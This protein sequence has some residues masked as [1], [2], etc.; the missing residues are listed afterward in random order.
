MAASLSLHDLFSR[1]HLLV[2]SFETSLQLIL[3]TALAA[4]NTT[5]YNCYV[6]DTKHNCTTAS[7]IVG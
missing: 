4:Q 7:Y 5:E 1:R 3:R 6:T 2:V